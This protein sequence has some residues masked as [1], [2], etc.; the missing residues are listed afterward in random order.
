MSDKKMELNI[1]CNTKAL[2]GSKLN[3][4]SVHGKCFPIICKERRI[5]TFGLIS[6]YTAK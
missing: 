1:I 3:I 5:F 2:R 6:L 4:N